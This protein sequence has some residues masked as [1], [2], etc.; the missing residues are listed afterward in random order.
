MLIELHCK[1]LQGRLTAGLA[2]Q[3]QLS[4]KRAFIPTPH[5]SYLDVYISQK[6]RLYEGDL[7]GKF[8]PR[9]QASIMNFLI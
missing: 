6:I 4:Q 2:K 5:C 1:F 3:R 7:E 9:V 8:Q